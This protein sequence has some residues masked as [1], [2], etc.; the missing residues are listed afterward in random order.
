MDWRVRVFDSLSFPTLILRPDKVIM[1]ANQIFLE[2][3]K[4]HQQIVGKKCHEL[5]YNTDEPCPPD[6]CPLEKVIKTKSGSSILKQE[7]SENGDERWED[8]VFSSILDDEGEVMY[9]MESIRDVTLLKTLEEE[10]EETRKFN[11]NVI[12][13]SASPIVVAN[14][15]GKVLVMN[16]AAEDL[17]GYS[18]EEYQSNISVE[19]VYPPGMAREIMQK[20]R[21]DTVGGKGKLPLTKFSI[22]NSK[23]EEIPT[24]MTAAILYENDQEVASMGIYNDLREKMAVEKKLKE[25]QVQLAQSEKMASMGQLAAGVAHEINNP[26]GG[27]LLYANLLLESLD[28][29]DAMREDLGYVIE[30][31]NRCKDIVKNLLAYSRQTNPTNKIIQLNDIVNQGLAL[32]RDPKLF[33]NVTIEKE[34]SDQMMLVS[35]DQKHLS[36]VV[37]N[38]V[39]NAVAAMENG[40]TLTLRTY[41]DKPT[42]KVYLEVTDTGCGIP[43]ENVAKVFDPFFSTKEQGKGTGLGLSTVYGIVKENGGN[44]SVKETSSEGTTFLLELPLYVPSD[45][46]ETG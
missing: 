34:L 16:P 29:N 20:L 11:K 4:E 21:D 43:E 36:Q 26:L 17:F 28:E 19:D 44:I 7:R 27:I 2:T 6:K 15:K 1:H 45:G 12:Q 35:S 30:D 13:S 38:L 18:L 24:E 8:R 41:R 9:I 40:G 37:I 10:L 39:M 5:W 22:I 31:A 23:G 33:N 46:G 42:K 32:M 3:Y 25:T 14:R